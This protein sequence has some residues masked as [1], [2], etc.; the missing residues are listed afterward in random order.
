MMAQILQAPGG[1]ATHNGL[2]LAGFPQQTQQPGKSLFDRVDAP[3]RKPNGSFSKRPYQNGSQHAKNHI[4]QITTEDGIEPSSLMDV[5]PSPQQA[6]DP[7][8]TMCYFNLTCTRADCH[9]VHQSPAAPP[10]TPVDMTDTCSFGA[11]CKNR[12]CVGKHPSPASAGPAKA[13]EDCKFFPN[14][15]NPACPFRHPTTAPCR[16]GADCTTPNCK[17]AHS[18]VPCKFDPCLNPACPFKHHEGQ[19]RGAFQ[20]KIWVGA[21]QGEKD[22]VSDRKFVDDTA[23]DED[24]VSFSQSAQDD[25]AAVIS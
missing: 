8:T 25:A 3:T 7:S 15:T 11:A 2:P 23:G 16:N 14:C 20:D 19:K 4:T 21:S 18:K 12:K 17:F 13:Q 10:G 6:S 1:Q 5:E 24:L 9:F 22:H